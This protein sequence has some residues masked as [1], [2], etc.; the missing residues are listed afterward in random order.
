MHAIFGQYD[1]DESGYLDGDEMAKLLHQLPIDGR[2]HMAKPFT[3]KDVKS[4]MR[5]FD[6]DDDAR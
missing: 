1:T 2:V 4:V 3:R 5:A 6:E